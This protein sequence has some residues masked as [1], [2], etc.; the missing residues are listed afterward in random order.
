MRFIDTLYT[1]SNRGPTPAV[2]VGSIPYKISSVFILRIRNETS[3]TTYK[4]RR[5]KLWYSV[6]SI[7]FNDQKT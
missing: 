1:Q 3:T 4:N 5:W 6:E 2:K 7:N